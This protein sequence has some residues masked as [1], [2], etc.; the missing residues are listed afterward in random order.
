MTH[1]DTSGAT[2]P[3]ELTIGQI[4]HVVVNVRDIDVSLPF[5][6]DV[7]GLAYEGATEVGGP[8]IGRLVRI[9][10]GSRG[11]NAFLSAGRG[12]GR[13]ELV[14]WVGGAGADYVNLPRR[15]GASPGFALL[16]FLLR[17]PALRGLYERLRGDY[18]CWSE[19]LDF[20]VGGRKVVGFVVEDPDGNPLELFALPD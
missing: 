1:I 9:P 16:S 13:V 6:R 19:P 2:P 12:M 15:N 8:G 4:H 14:E 20:V 17:E 11:R 5:Y 3:G 18:V 10:E 7:L